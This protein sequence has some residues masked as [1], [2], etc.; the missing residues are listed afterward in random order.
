MLLLEPKAEAGI[1]DQTIPKPIQT[2]KSI[3]WYKARPGQNLDHSC[4]SNWYV[5]VVS[6]SLRERDTTMTYGSRRPLTPIASSSTVFQ[7]LDQ[8]QTTDRHLNAAKGDR[9]FGDES[10]EP[11]E[12]ESLLGFLEIGRVKQ[13]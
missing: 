11:P 7:F 13:L 4:G 8:T 1:I 6:R 9:L 3:P 10:G 12:N 5:M 2:G